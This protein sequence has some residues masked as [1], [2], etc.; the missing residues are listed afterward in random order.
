MHMPHMRVDAGVKG[1][2][3]EGLDRESGEKWGFDSIC[4]KKK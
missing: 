2:W 4:N 3:G 1:E